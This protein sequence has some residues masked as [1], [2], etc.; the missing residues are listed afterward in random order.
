MPFSLKYSVMLIPSG[1][2][3]C[4]FFTLIKFWQSHGCSD[5]AMAAPA[6]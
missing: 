4:A 3:M 2:P 1:M 6:C 5:N